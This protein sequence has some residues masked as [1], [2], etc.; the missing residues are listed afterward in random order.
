MI[1]YPTLG[2]ITYANDILAMFEDYDNNFEFT[3]DGIFRQRTPPACPKCSVQTNRNGW[4]P[5]TKQG[6]GSVKIGRYECP[7]CGEHYED[8]PGFWEKMKQEFLSVAGVVYQKMR[9]FHMPHQGISELMSMIFPSGLHHGK[10]TVSRIFTD[11]LREVNIPPV[12]DI[13]FVLYDEQHPKM[14]RTQK[15][16]LT[17]L[18]F[19]TGR[20][21][22]EELHSTMDPE[23][24]K[25]FLKKHLDTEKPIFIVT[26]LLPTYPNVFKEVFGEKLIHQLCL[27]HLNKRIVKDF[28]RNTTLEQE[29]VKY[30]LLN[31]FYN[32]DRE[33]NNL[34][35]LMDEEKLMK[36][37]WFVFNWKDITEN[38]GQLRDFLENVRGIKWVKNAEI[39][40]IDGKE[41]IIVTSGKNSLKLKLNKEKS[42]VTIKIK[43]GESYEYIVKE[44]DN[45]LNAYQKEYNLWLKSSVKRFR[46][47]VHGLELERRRNKKNHEQRSYEDAVDV[48]SNLMSKFDSYDKPIQKRLNMIKKNWANLTQFYFV[49]GAPA[50]NNR[51]ENYYSTSLKT[52]QKKKFRADASIENQMKLSE[53]KRCGML[54]KCKSSL[55]DVLLKFRMLCAPG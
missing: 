45:K 21:I 1:L 17:L 40:K 37:K 7:I 53:M 4:N 50:T 41:V 38:D 33:I 28:P 10:D 20:P 19:V 22:A 51:I 16:R 27:L 8:D 31:I 9:S 47:F 12:E 52:H 13:Q 2:N 14:N 34:K 26:D 6:L 23:T 18:D 15:Y 36:Q 32:R 49:E 43:K 44:E 30:S 48:F 42:R 5:H 24:I 29:L 46:S 11:A 54:D 39:K 3:A 25:T 55:F 35:D